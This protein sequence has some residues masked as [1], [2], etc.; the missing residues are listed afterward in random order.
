MTKQVFGLS[1]GEI[2]LRLRT[3]R[4]MVRIGASA[5]LMAA[6]AL[7]KPVTPIEALAQSADATASADDESTIYRPATPVGTPQPEPTGPAETFVGPPPGQ[8]SP[9]PGIAIDAFMDLSLALVG[10]GKLDPDR[11]GQLLALIAADTERRTALDSLLAIRASGEV[12]TPI[13]TPVAALSLDDR[14]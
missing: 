7:L 5:A 2:L 11:G 9:V 14:R 10:G 1:D 12:A 4:D 13:A 6:P 3:R 8:A